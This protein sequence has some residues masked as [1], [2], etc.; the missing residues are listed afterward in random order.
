LLSTDGKTVHCS[1][2]LATLPRPKQTLADI[3]SAIAC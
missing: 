1:R 2:G 3:R